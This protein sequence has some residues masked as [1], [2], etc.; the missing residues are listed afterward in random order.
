MPARLQVADF[1]LS[2]ASN[3][4]GGGDAAEDGEE[5]Y[6]RAQKSAFPIRWTAPEAMETMLFNIATDV[7][8]FGVLMLEIYLDGDRP[9]RGMD[10]QTVISRVASGYRA[11]RPEGCSSAAYNGIILKCWSADPAARPT[12]A[13]IADHLEAIALG[14]EGG[15]RGGGGAGAGGA[16]GSDCL[17][18][19]VGHGAPD[20][21][22]YEMPDDD[23]MARVRGSSFAADDDDDQDGYNMPDESNM[24]RI[25]GSA[26]AGGGALGDN[27]DSDGYDMPDES[28]MARL[29]ARGRPRAAAKKATNSPGPA[30]PAHE[31]EYSGVNEYD[32]ATQVLTSVAPQPTQSNGAGA[33]RDQTR[34]VLQLEV[35]FVC[36]MRVCGMCTFVP[37]RQSPLAVWLGARAGAAVWLC[38]KW[39]RHVCA[40]CSFRPWQ[41]G[42]HCLKLVAHTRA[43]P[44]ACVCL[45]RQ[46]FATIAETS[47][48]AASG[49]RANDSD[50]ELEL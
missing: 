16:L 10:N 42:R 36:E 41:D 34:P 22:S 17:A 47:I 29:S 44:F 49:P 37:G 26:Q 8:S 39:Q 9:Y 48:D 30:P 18:P 19:T 3:G 21:D 14:A 38:P 20:D 40:R 6:Y 32:L 35:T 24:A 27:S 5:V 1:G 45:L 2:R 23:N 13:S 28:N 15:G 46:G 33:A 11:P 7:W 4:G 31:Y 25:R 50:Y 12:F 43:C